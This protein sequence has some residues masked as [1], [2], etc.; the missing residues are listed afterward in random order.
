MRL[1]IA[2]KLPPMRL[3][4]G[5]LVIILRKAWHENGGNGYH[6]IIKKV[7]SKTFIPWSIKIEKR[8]FKLNKI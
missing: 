5:C 3:I 1:I 4:P 6:V 8:R 2:G 7:K